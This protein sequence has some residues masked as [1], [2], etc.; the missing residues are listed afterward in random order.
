MSAGEAS[1]QLRLALLLEGYWSGHKTIGSLINLY[2][3]FHD[4]DETKTR[5]QVEWFFKNKVPEIEKSGKWKPY[6]CT[7]LENLNIC[8][9]S[10]CPIYRQRQKRNKLKN[11]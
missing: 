1:H 2:R 6:C 4:F 3:G 5:E 10:E 7:T 11:V 8:L 9:K